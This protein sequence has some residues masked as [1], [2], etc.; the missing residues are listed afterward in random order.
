MFVCCVIR[1]VWAKLIMFVVV[2][3]FL[4]VML[5]LIAFCQA[6]CESIIKSR[7]T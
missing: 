4:S 6:A 2:V 3:M 1:Y 7:I 5:F